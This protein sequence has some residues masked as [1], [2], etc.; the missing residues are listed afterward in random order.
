VKRLL[1]RF[2]ILI[3][4]IVI[5]LLS[6]GT[7]RN[8]HNKKAVI[9]STDSAAPTE[10]SPL[11]KEPETPDINIPELHSLINQER[12]KNGVINL[13][14]SDT[15]AITAQH[16]CEDMVA[17]K[18]WS[19]NT[20]DGASPWTFIRPYIPKYHKLGENLAERFR[21]AVA[22]KDGWM[23]SPEHRNNI[24]DNNYQYEGL[25]VC[26]SQEGPDGKG[27]ALIVV[28]HFVGY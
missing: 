5:A 10:P 2:F 1:L 16:K 9:K 7:L 27:P 3:F 28:E 11:L 8:L 19:H 18:Y 26:K 20:P 17:R 24:L 22:V 21:S 12:A 15:L 23:I 6:I 13:N 4:F 25:A 14:Y